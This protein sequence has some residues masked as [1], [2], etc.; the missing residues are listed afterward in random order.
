[1]AKAITFVMKTRCT[2]WSAITALP[3]AIVIRQDVT[4]G[5]PNG[6]RHAIA[7]IYSENLRVLGMMPHPENL[8]EALVGGTDGQSL[9]ASLAAAG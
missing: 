2:S 5:N 4:R 7:G 6:S 9:F 1:M 8:V 3:S